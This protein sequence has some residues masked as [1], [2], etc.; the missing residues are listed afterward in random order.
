MNNYL[1]LYNYEKF[2]RAY[3]RTDNRDKMSEDDI[4]KYLKEKRIQA[5]PGAKDQR[6]NNLDSIDFTVKKD[7]IP[8]SIY[9]DYY[10]GKVIIYF[11][12]FAL[13]SKE[14]YDE[15]KQDYDNPDFPK[16]NNFHRDERIVK[17]CLVDNLFIY[18]LNENIL[19][20]GIPKGSFSKFP[21]F[22]T[23]FFIIMNKECTN[24]NLE[25][26][27]N[28][29]FSSKDLEKYLINRN[30]NLSKDSH[31]KTIDMMDKK[32]KIGMIYN[33]DFD[34]EKYQDRSIKVLVNKVNNKYKKKEIDD[35]NNNKNNNNENNNNKIK[36]L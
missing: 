34:F 2:K 13:L 1:E 35:T 15:I 25:K 14:I 21:I 30:V 24:S 11:Y 10:S 5:Q 28:K 26:E 36:S 31:Q 17:I 29:L 27:I 6:I 12:D 32:E 20:I 3:E 33:I 8:K 16:Y 19:G 7:N 22:T 23:Q 9:T 4:Y 18:K